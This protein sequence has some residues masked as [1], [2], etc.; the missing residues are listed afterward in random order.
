LAK[1]LSKFQFYKIREAGIMLR[2]S[3]LT[4]LIAHSDEDLLNL[5]LEK[6]KISP[7][8][9]LGYHVRRKSVDARKRG[10]VF[11]VYTVDVEIDPATGNEEAIA[12]KIKNASIA[13]PLEYCG[14]SLSVSLPAASP[15]PVIIG[16]GPCGLFAGLILAEAGLRPLLLE[17]GKSAK[18]RAKDVV[19]FWKDAT[20]NENSNVQFG[21]GGAGTFSDGKLTTQIK[22][23]HNRCRKVLEELVAAGAAEEILYLAKPHIGTDVLIKVVT[24]LRER[25]IALGGEVRFESHVTE[26]VIEDNKVNGVVLADGE[27]IQT[28]IVIAAIGHSA[29][30]TYE[31][32]HNK[33]VQCE[34]KAFSI[35]ARI[36]HHQG[37]IDKSQYGKFANH[38][39][40]GH[41]EYKL[42]HHCGSGRDVYTFC[43]CPGGS[44]IGAS[45]E[46]GGVVT[47]GM[48]TF[49]RNAS[50]AN[51]ALLVGVKP[52]DFGSDH[53]LAGISFQRIWEQAAF[54]L[55]GSC[56]NAPAQRVEDFLQGRPTTHAGSVKPSYSPSVCYCDISH[57]L[58]AF[59]V[60]AMRVAIPQ[61]DKKIR[62]FAMKDSILTAPETRSS[63][64]VRITRNE[65]LE[66][67]NT[68]GLYPAG[69][70]AGYAGGIMSAAVDGIKAAESIVKKITET[71]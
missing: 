52:S 25:I 46:P 15:R 58:P 43:M 55:A 66:S 21:E 7:E 22:D 27:E 33:G 6:L 57:C 28:D 70:G 71:S 47:N 12:A 61:F 9:L 53:P 5:I 8:M 2:L 18:A 31:E 64:P 3:S 34:Q 26:L 63:S 10:V 48:S 16:T 29:R 40:I 35:G 41:A 60:K 45:S 44:V 49:S 67:V 38:P 50:N 69:E 42:V 62:G 68:S 56:Y 37:I 32:L 59:A 13:K 11:F 23:K 20:L 19:A 17:R 39:A 30:D 1:I 4:L 65:M 36:E 51:S 24:N 14:P 54:R